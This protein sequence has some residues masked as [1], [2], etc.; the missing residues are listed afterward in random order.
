MRG[1]VG[2]IRVNCGGNT[3]GETFGVDAGE[4]YD[5]VV[6]LVLQLDHDVSTRAVVTML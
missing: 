3:P 2:S 6:T 4:I 5:A 1:M